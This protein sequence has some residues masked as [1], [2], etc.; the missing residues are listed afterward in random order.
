[1]NV[2]NFTKK[3]FYPSRRDKRHYT[4]KNGDNILEVIVTSQYKLVYVKCKQIEI[5]FDF[6]NFLAQILTSP[7]LKVEKGFSIKIH[8]NTY[9]LSLPG[10]SPFFSF[11]KQ[12]LHF[13]L[14][15]NKVLFFNTI[16]QKREF[17]KY[18]NKKRDV[19][20]TIIKQVSRVI[21]K[22]GTC[23][24]NL[25]NLVQ[26]L[27]LDSHGFLFVEENKMFQKIIVVCTL[28]MKTV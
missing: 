2:I 23:A 3:S 15:M 5:I 11:S 24:C 20:E 4:L 6:L 18:S 19:L 10:A 14:K 8:A 13:F 28:Y 22:N 9:F 16:L 21:P 12:E 27:N 17:L 1:M 7:C 25:S 26:H